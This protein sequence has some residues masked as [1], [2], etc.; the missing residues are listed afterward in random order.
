[1]ASLSSFLECCTQVE[2]MSVSEEEVDTVIA[3]A[4]T[5]DHD[6]DTYQSSKA[7]PSSLA[8]STEVGRTALFNDREDLEQE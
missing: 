6:I 5:P 3:Y 7:V 1:M 8:T 2:W 4:A